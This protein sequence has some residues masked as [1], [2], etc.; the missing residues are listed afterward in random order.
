MDEPMTNRYGM[1]F[2]S[3]AEKA[4]W[5]AYVAARLAA[6]EQT[7]LLSEAESERRMTALLEKLA[8]ALLQRRSNEP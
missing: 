1:A 7:P 6:A 8:Q 3:E 4:A 5:D 2:T